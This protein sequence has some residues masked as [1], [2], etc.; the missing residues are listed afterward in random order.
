MKKKL[1]TLREKI[2]L[3]AKKRLNKTLLTKKG[4]VPSKLN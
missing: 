2:S 4:T 1:K 3:K